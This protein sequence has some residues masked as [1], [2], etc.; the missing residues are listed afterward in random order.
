[1]NSSTETHSP[2]PFGIAIKIILVILVGE[3]LIRAAIDSIFTPFFAKE[4]SPLFWEFVDPVLLSIILAPVL[5]FV[6][7]RPMRKQ[8]RL[9]ESQ[10]QEL[11]QQKDELKIAAATFEAQDGILITDAN[12]VIL[13]INQ[14]FSE[15]T[16]YTDEEVIGKTP[17]ILQSGRHDKEFYRRMWESLANDNFWIGEIWNRR[18]NGEIYPEFLTITSL[19][20][21]DSNITN[22]IGTFHDIT[23][24]KAAED[25]I[26]FLAFYDPLT[27]LAN[28][29]LM[30]D[31]MEQLL[32]LA[33]R[34]GELVAIC[35]IDLDGF[36]QVNDQKGHKAGDQLLVEVARRLKECIRQSDTASRLGGDE[37]ALVLGGFNEISEC[38]QSL[39]RINAALAAPYSVINQ[40][41]YVT[42]SIG[43]TIFPND[44]SNAD[45]LLRHADESM[46]EAKHAG[47]NCYRL[48]NPSHQNQQA[49]NQTTFKKIEN[50]LTENQFAIYYQPQV[51]C[52]L[53]KI[54]GFEALIR[55][56]HPILG[57]LLPADFI[58]LIENDDL[59]IRL[60]EWVI[61][62]VL[63]QLKEWRSK[64]VDVT[65][66][67][68]ISARQLHQPDFIERLNILL[69][70]YESDIVLHFEIEL[71]ETAALEDINAIA[72]AIRKCRELGIQIA[73]DDFGT[74]FFSLGHLRKM[75]FD[76][77]KIDK[78]FIF[79]MLRNPE[80][81]VLV[82]SVIGLAS[83][84]KRKVIA[85]GVESIDQVLML[86]ELGCQHMQGYEIARPMPADQVLAWVEQFEPNPLWT[87]DNSYRPSRDYFE[88]L[89]A[90]VNHRHWI[91][92]LVNERCEM[93]NDTCPEMI[94]DH[95]CRF[96]HWYYG[97]GFRQFGTEKWFLSIEPLHQQ[98]HRSAAM[99]CEQ[100]RAGNLK[101]ISETEATLLAQSDELILLL[102][103]FRVLLTDRYRQLNNTESYYDRTQPNRVE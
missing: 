76:A 48:F 37:F 100:K 70:G 69:S 87:L 59:I 99:L 61:R 22:Y 89:L 23:S 2:S 35:M 18:K 85:E 65:I 54:T 31:R 11:E 39:T 53:G 80:D 83:S 95:Q 10:K 103:K 8:Q 27:G 40:T 7:L 13:K 92:N 78:N 67:V 91:E 16:G 47:K 82:N 84:F 15:I 75:P 86:L 41:A 79:G 102:R 3:F 58:P 42:A 26:K 30:T 45:Q 44:G 98:I 96:G 90:E 34:S 28:R 49:A 25:E 12:L 56:Q 94:D 20:D 60:G 101:E 50:A 32:S 66:A 43:V 74:G 62:N 81:L 9:M 73:I 4:A 33:R 14:S 52:R 19:R 55:W 21:S 51:D 46:Y 97:D 6:V 1:M 64:G 5:Y 29:R 88:M 63:T 68:N 71:L 72:V 93:Q 24:S 17:S 57:M 36:K 38:T 77:L